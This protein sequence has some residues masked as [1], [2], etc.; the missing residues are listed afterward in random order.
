MDQP[1]QHPQRP[2]DVQCL[3]LRWTNQAIGHYCKIL[4]LNASIANYALRTFQQLYEY[5]VRFQNDR[6][7]VI[8]ASIFLA[9][10]YFKR[11]MRYSTT[12]TLVR[13]SPES[14]FIMLL[15]AEVVLHQSREPPCSGGLRMPEYLLASSAPCMNGKSIRLVDGSQVK[16]TSEYNE[17]DPP[18]LDFCWPNVVAMTQD[19]A[20]SPMQ[21]KHHIANLDIPA[22]Q[23]QTGAKIDGNIMQSKHHIA[24]LDIPA[25]QAQTGAKIDGNIK[26]SKYH[27]ARG[28]CSA[29]PGSSATRSNEDS[30]WNLIEYEDLAATEDCSDQWNS[31][32]ESARPTRT[33]A[34]AIRRNLFGSIM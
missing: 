7:A 21:S 3:E 12:L 19:V 22:T 26:E 25:T 1:R 34:G 18:M 29:V 9:C 24:N 2:V 14:G 4:K 11:S 13:V 15:S 23:A 20:L 31:V 5:D 30:D 10:R 28:L 16:V 6:H 33:W 17:S 8:A 27:A 32:V